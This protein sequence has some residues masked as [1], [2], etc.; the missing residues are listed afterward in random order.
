MTERP[1]SPSTDHVCA[2]TYELAGLRLTSLRAQQFA[3]WLLA[4]LATGDAR[5]LPPRRVARLSWTPSSSR[6]APARSDTT[7]ARD[8][9]SPLKPVRT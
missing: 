7:V 5:C 8:R 2:A 9:R 4:R 1:V 6:W 3:V